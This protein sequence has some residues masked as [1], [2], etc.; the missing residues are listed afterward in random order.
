MREGWTLSDTSADPQQ[1]VRALS[2]SSG[3]TCVGTILPYELAST[4][5]FF[6]HHVEGNTLYKSLI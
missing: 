6:L 3:N 1:P 4:Y 2:L 5:E